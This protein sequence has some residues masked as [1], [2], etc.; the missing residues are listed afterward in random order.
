LAVKVININL[1]GTFASVKKYL[2]L[3]K[4]ELIYIIY[5]KTCY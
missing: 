1:I 5:E 3:N 2:F 4:D